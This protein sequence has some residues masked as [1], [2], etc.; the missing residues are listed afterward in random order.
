MWVPGYHTCDS[1]FLYELLFRL[2]SKVVRL[3]GG[4]LGIVGMFSS[5]LSGWCNTGKPAGI[6]HTSHLMWA[7]LPSR[8]CSS[9]TGPRCELIN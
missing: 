2:L 6:L 7:L 9:E 1:A 3:C 8:F 5:F 4:C